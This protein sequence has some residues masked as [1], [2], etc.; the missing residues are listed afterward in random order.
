MRPRPLRTMLAAAIIERADNQILIVLPAT[1][2]GLRKW[3]FPRGAARPDESA[4]AAMRRVA[5]EQ[6]GLTVEL[7][8]GQP[9]IMATV[10]GSPAEVRYFFCGIAFGEVRAGPY[11]E[12]RWV[13]RAHLRE[14]EF[15]EASS[16]VVDWLLSS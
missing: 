2:D 7:V 1:N 10:D 11:A 4:E 15:E 9:P 14:Y 8:I 12:I 5:H 3:M 13:S 16:P 6:L